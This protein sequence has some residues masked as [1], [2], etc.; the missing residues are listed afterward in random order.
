MKIFSRIIDVSHCWWCGGTNLSREHKFKK[1]D[2]E[3]LYG[4]TYT[5]DN[6]ISNTKFRTQSRGFFL[7]SSNSTLAKFEGTICE[8]CNNS[9]SQRFD[10]SY[11]KLIN[12][13]YTHKLSILHDTKI[14]LRDVFGKDWEIGIL[15][16]QKYIAKHV[17]SRIVDFGYKPHK[18]LIDFINGEAGNHDLKIVFRYKPY[19]IG[20]VNDPIECIFLGPLNNFNNSQD[21]SAGI[22]TS[23]SGWYTFVNF[24]WNYIYEENINCYSLLDDELKLDIIKY[25][26]PDILNIRVKMESLETDWGKGLEK[27]E[28]YPHLGN[29]RDMLHYQYLKGY[30]QTIADSAGDKTQY[31]FY[32]I[33]LIAV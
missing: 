28:Y 21:R 23:F 18:N 24:S 7:Q 12:Y 11:E 30:K 33:K 8:T 15:N 6:I 9:K 3:L 19:F 29:D 20:D 16:V 10:K 4:K 26:D 1:T 25:E 32:E 13:Y 5:P 27:I 17:A 2:L 22:I 31:N 14:S